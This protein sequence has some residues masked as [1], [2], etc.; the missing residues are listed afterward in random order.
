MSQNRNKIL[1]QDW[2]KSHISKT[3]T[4]IVSLRGPLAL[5]SLFCRRSIEYVEHAQIILTT[6]DL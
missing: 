4:I 2:D 1:L 6:V 3:G 5:P